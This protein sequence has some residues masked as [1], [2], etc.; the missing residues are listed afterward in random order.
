M[1]AI[2]PGFSTDGVLTTGIDL[3]GAGY[4]TQRAVTFQDELLDRLPRISGVDSA[5]FART[6]PFSYRPYSTATIAVDGFENAPGEA[7]I[8]EYNEVGPGYFATMGTPLIS[9]REFTRDDNETSSLVAVVNERLARQYWP[10]QDPVGKRLIVKD[11]PMRV[12][13]VAAVAK[14]GNLLETPKPFFYVPLRQNVLGQNLN[15]RT[16]LRPER[17]AAAL[18]NEI[19]ALDPGLAPSEITTMREQVDRNTSAQTIA[20]RLLGVFGGVA[21]LLAAIGL[22]GLMSFSVAQSTR[23]MGMRMALGATQ[24]NLLQLVVSRGLALTAG[25]VVFGAAAALVSTRLLGYLLYQ[26]SPRDPVA[27]GAAL[28][29]MV[30]ASLAACLLP[31]WRAMRTDPIRALRT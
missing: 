30:I 1:R 22:Y 2:N 8:A 17:M 18:V 4:D 12:V 7:P 11:R 3:I 28:T 23:E 10:G 29:V 24:S 5:A 15:I 31:A 20:V 9:G 19:H 27:F 25:G 21:L 26:V 13:G 6:V 14:Y 16:S